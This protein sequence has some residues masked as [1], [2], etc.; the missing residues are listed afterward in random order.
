MQS[1]EYLLTLWSQSLIWTQ[2]FFVS[3]LMKSLTETNQY[4]VDYQK[5]LF[6]PAW[7][8]AF[9]LSFVQ[10]TTRTYFLFS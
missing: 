5:S 7:P 6:L 3:I 10:S 4:L 2:V 1:K 8:N 9:V